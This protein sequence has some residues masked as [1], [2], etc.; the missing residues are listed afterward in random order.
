MAN[1]VA[2]QIRCL[3]HYTPSY[4]HLARRLR[5]ASL[6]KW[7]PGQVNTNHFILTQL[8]LFMNSAATLA[9]IGPLI[10]QYPTITS[11]WTDVLNQTGSASRSLLRRMWFV[12]FWLGLKH[13]KICIL[14]HFFKFSCLEC[15]DWRWILLGNIEN[16]WH[17]TWL[18]PQGERKQRSS[19]FFSSSR[20]ASI[21]YFMWVSPSFSC[22]SQQPECV[23]VLHHM[24]NSFSNASQYT[25]V[26][27]LDHR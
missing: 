9:P 23:H 22:F 7:F 24:A 16:S 1:M 11:V 13:G 18:Q 2:L 20:G 26:S 14:F 12:R 8:P 21:L 27:I 5:W 10:I 3:P 6:L 19:W 17:N 25:E 15:F 4:P